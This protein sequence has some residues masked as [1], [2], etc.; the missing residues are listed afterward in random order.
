MY[1]TS[2]LGIDPNDNLKR[3]VYDSCDYSHYT[4]YVITAEA[5]SGDRVVFY[6]RMYSPD[7]VGGSMPANLESAQAT[8]DGITRATGDY[9]SLVYSADHHNWNEG[10]TIILRPP[11]GDIFGLVLIDSGYNDDPVQMLYL[12]SGLTEIRTSPL[13]SYSEEKQ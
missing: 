9:F 12:G 2:Q 8:V 6:K 11:V 7:I 1:L 5:Q 13:T 4:R 3:Q 10:Y